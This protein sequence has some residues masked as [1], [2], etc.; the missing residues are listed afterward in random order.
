VP[1]VTASVTHYTPYW[2]LAVPSRPGAMLAAAQK[3]PTAAFLKDGPTIPLMSDGIECQ[4][5]VWIEIAGLVNKL[6]VTYG[7][8]PEALP[9]AEENADADQIPSENG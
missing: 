5:Y 7:A 3:A 4:H 2:H 9:D 8:E 1:L 6:I